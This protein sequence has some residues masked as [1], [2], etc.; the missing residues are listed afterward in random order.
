MAGT[1]TLRRRADGDRKRRNYRYLDVRPYAPN[2]G[3]EVR[4]IDLVEG[5]TEDAFEEVRNAFLDHQ[6][7]FFKEQS[8]I[9]PDTHIAIGR[10]FGELHR[11]P[12]APHLDGQIGRE[13]V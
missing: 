5:L 8:P 11:H 13:H 7:L 10:M 9:P 2:L 3:A 6:I 12:A 1:D 4:G